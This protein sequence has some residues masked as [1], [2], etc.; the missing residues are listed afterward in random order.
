MKN[1]TQGNRMGQLWVAFLSSPSTG[2]APADR[3]RLGEP[4]LGPAS[5]PLTVNS[6]PPLDCSHHLQAQATEAELETHTEEPPQHGPLRRAS[7]MCPQ[8]AEPSG[9]PG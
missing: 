7:R 9:H 6:P 3:G 8:D 2:R 1:P 5:S 4:K